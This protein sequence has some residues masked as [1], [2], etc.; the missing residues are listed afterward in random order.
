MAAGKGADRYIKFKY[1]VK[2]LYTDNENKDQS[3]EEHEAVLENHKC[4]KNSE[5][6]GRGYMCMPG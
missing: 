5:R 2:L 3:K 4:K 6:K 1:V